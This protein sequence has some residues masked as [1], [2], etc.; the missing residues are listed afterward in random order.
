MSMTMG[1]KLVNVVLRGAAGVSFDTRAMTAEGQLL[2]ALDFKTKAA[3]VRHALFEG[4]A[5]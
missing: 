3:Q 1:S 2:V 5:V 4:F